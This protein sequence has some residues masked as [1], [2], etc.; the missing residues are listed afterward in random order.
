VS[1][2]LAVIWNI[3][4]KKYERRLPIKV[5]DT[6]RFARVNEGID[7][8]EIVSEEPSARG[9]ARAASFKRTAAKR[10]TVTWPTNGN[11]H[12]H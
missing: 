11:V 4:H 3:F 5:T 9:R 8:G 7:I 12:K 6:M 1:E 10:V 2:F